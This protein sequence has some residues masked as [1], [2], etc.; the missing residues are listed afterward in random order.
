MGERCGPESRDEEAEE[1]QENFT[2][3]Q[4]VQRIKAGATGQKHK[5]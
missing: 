4:I 3:N 5:P 1:I 2:V